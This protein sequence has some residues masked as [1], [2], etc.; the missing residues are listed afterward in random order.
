MGEHRAQSTEVHS[1][2]WDAATLRL[3]QQKAEV[4]WLQTRFADSHPES[5]E[6]VPRSLLCAFL[7]DLGCAQHI[8]PLATVPK[9][10]SLKSELI[11]LSLLWPATNPASIF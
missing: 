3:G 2:C 8:K 11:S 6:Y 10:C 4:N 1:I 9:S 7:E 5:W